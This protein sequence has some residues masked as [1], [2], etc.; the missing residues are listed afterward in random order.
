MCLFYFVVFLSMSL[1]KSLTVFATFLPLTS[2]GFHIR[3][4]L[5]TANRVGGGG[6]KEEE[7][8]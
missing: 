4:K 2:F 8:A 7:I 3:V 6:K 5:F 1:L